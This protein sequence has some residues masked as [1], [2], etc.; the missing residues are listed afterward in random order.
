MSD[1]QVAAL[2]QVLRQPLHGDRAGGRIEIDHDVAAEDHVLF[3]SHGISGLKK[4]DPLKLQALP[5]FTLD[6]TGPSPDA[7]AFLKIALQQFRVY[8]L[9]GIHSIDALLS[10]SEHAPGDIRGGDL[11]LEWGICA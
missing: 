5:E 4:I 7:D 2:G 3:P 6:P 10:V 9:D 8:R 11:P 1:N